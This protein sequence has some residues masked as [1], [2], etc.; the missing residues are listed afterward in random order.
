M[1]VDLTTEEKTAIIESHQKS[2]T[3]NQ[4]N[5]QISLVEENSKAFPDHSIIANLEKQITDASNQLAALEAQ[6]SQLP[7]TPATTN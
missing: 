4:Y 5:L 7:A 1:A 6:I 2:I 3:Y